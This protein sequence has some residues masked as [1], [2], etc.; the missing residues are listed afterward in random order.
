VQKGIQQ[1][2]DLDA[3]AKKDAK[4]LA[5][6]AV[7]RIDSVVLVAYAMATPMYSSM[8]PTM[9]RISTMVLYIML[10]PVAVRVMVN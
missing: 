5:V 6:A 3:A 4:F 9:R 8:I 1:E 7:R 2:I 10:T